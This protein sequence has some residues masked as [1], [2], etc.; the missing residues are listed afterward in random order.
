L[1]RSEIYFI[2]KQFSAWK[3][4]NIEYYCN[5]ITFRE[6]RQTKRIADEYIAFSGQKLLLVKA[7]IEKVSEK[8]SEKE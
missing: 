3:G 4:F 2:M 7:K 6:K 1:F 5:T 8:V